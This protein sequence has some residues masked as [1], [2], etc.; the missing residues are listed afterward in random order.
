MSL[1]A[2]SIY[3]SGSVMS[4]NKNARIYFVALFARQ[5]CAKLVT[6]IFKTVFCLSLLCCLK[7]LLIKATRVYVDGDFQYIQY[8]F[9]TVYAVFFCTVYAFAAFH[10]YV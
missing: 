2:K 8:I 6:K 7:D 5:A 3:F 1:A 10:L 4:S 9:S